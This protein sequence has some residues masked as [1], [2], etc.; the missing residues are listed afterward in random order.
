MASTYKAVLFDFGGVILSSP[1]DA[2]AEYERANGL[3]ENFLRTIN[4]TNHTE[5]AWAKLERSEVDIDGFAPLFEAEALA[6]GHRVDARAV[7]ALLA[8]V[9]RPEMVR[10][11]DVIRDAGLATACLTN[12][13]V[14]FDD[15]SE[16]VRAEGR[17]AVLARFDVIIESSKVGLR[18]PDPR[19]YEIAC[20]A[21]GVAPRDC[22][23]L[24]DL[25]VNLKP[26]RAMGMTTIKVDDPAVALAELATALG[27][28]VA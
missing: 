24:D 22:V 6:A 1:F 9:I 12:N 10:A 20:E 5:N 3:P 11:I 28:S 19:F 25:G 27:F 26:A 16:D 23:F 17:D 4:A 7:L 8:G 2:F 14:A 18:K 13:F 15:F 21:L